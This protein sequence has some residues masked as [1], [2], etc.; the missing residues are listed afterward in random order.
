[1]APS[2]SSSIS[3]SPSPAAPNYPDSAAIDMI[4]AQFAPQIADLIAGDDLDCGAAC[5][6][7]STGLVQLCDATSADAKGSFHGMPGRSVKEGQPVTLFGPGTR[8]LYDIGAPFFVGEQLFL[9]ATPGGLTSAPQTGDSKGVA[10]AVSTTDIVI[11]NY[12][13]KGG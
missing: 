7:A 6:I 10:I 12:K 11:T 9:D 4:T 13:L 5:Y 3:P 1:M 8:F 2:P